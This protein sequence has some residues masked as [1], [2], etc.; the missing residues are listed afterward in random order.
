MEDQ[1]L[2][3]GDTVELKS[4]GPSMTIQTIHVDGKTVQA[5][6][7][8][9]SQSTLHASWFQKETLKKVSLG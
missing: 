3:V 1:K 9:N 7:F 2:V 5:V 6:W 8:P 4:G